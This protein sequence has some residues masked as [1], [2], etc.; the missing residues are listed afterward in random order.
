METPP[1]YKGVGLGD[2]V[3]WSVKLNQYNGDLCLVQKIKPVSLSYIGWNY[4]GD[5]YF[6]LLNL[7]KNEIIYGDN[8]HLSAVI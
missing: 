2:L 4:C 3:R 5:Y 1:E 7:T 6:E 8:R